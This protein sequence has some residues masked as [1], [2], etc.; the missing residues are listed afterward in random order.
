MVAVLTLPKTEGVGIQS[1]MGGPGA[2]G[3]ERCSGTE[4]GGREETGEEKDLLEWAWA[5]GVA[6]D[7]PCRPVFCAGSGCRGMVASRPITK[8]EVILA[9]PSDILMSGD[10]AVQSPAVCAVLE[11]A[12]CEGEQLCER[13]VLAAHLLLERHKGPSSKWHA[14]VASIPC[15]YDT[16][17]YWT[18]D[19]VASL[20]H[21]PL[22]KMALTRRA[23]I[24]EEFDQLCR[25]LERH[26]GLGEEGARELKE[27]L[28]WDSYRWAAAT[29]S[30]R[31]CHYVPTSVRARE[32]RGEKVGTLVPLLDMLNHSPESTAASCALS[33]AELPR[34]RA[35]QVKAVR[36][37]KKGEEIFIQYGP[38]P[39]AGLLQHYGCV[40]ECLRRHAMH[41][42]CASV[43]GPSDRFAPSLIR[44]I[45][46]DNPMDGCQVYLT[47]PK[48]LELEM[49]ESLQPDCIGNM[50]TRTRSKKK[51]KK[52]HAQTS[53]VV[54]EQPSKDV[55]GGTGEEEAK[56][57]RRAAAD[58]YQV[59]M[60]LGKPIAP[61]RVEKTDPAAA[62][63]GKMQDLSDGCQEFELYLQ[64]KVGSSHHG[65]TC[66]TGAQDE[67]EEI[68]WNVM[69]VMRWN[70]LVR[71]HAAAAARGNDAAR[72]CYE[73]MAAVVLEADHGDYSCFT[74]GGVRHILHVMLS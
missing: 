54:R 64:T 31:S 72:D 16:V 49:V 58:V 50:Q 48:P 52:Y 4:L 36:A 3:P 57:G 22:V 15:A 32:L 73:Q 5:Q 68:P 9:I 53:K 7:M 51:A 24:R 1:R 21:M 63:L 10:S 37:Y 60:S 74:E 62:S 12:K 45:L 66:A 44:F 30:T 38:W 8:G 39:N 40:S 23:M 43:R 28:T 42:A 14:F 13:Q 6:R 19:D 25:L 35:Y 55:H 34:D 18:H 56:A 41:R 70:E 11:S 46:P 2:A 69:T 65:L 67:D 20:Q 26:G 33:D 61:L 59:L 17:E 27:I 47:S 29:V 71:E